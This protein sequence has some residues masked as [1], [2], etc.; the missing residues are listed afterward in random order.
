MGGRDL[1]VGGRWEE[2]G[3]GPKAAGSRSSMEEEKG[4]G[5]KGKGKAEARGCRCQA[6]G[7]LPHHLHTVCPPPPACPP[8]LPPP[9]DPLLPPLV[10]LHCLS[11]MALSTACCFTASPTSPYHLDYYCS[12]TARPTT[13]PPLTP[14][15]SVFPRHLTNYCPLSTF[16]EFK[17]ILQKLDSIHEKL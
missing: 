14:L 13:C 12:L 8:L 16:S 9:P 5:G 3:Q 15:L 1:G 10:I 6:Q 17:A 4:R 7:S 2:V 11:P